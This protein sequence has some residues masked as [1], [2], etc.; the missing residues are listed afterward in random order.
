M[1]RLRRT[2]ISRPPPKPC[3]AAGCD[4][5]RKARK[6][7]GP[8]YAADL[9]A[10]QPPAVR[11]AARRPARPARHRHRIPARVRRVV[12]ARAAGRCEGC[13]GWLPARPH[14]HHRRLLSQGGR[15]EPA[16]LVA[17]CPACHVD[18]PLT[19]RERIAESGRGHVLP[20]HKHVA[21]ARDL[22]LIV[23]GTADPAAESLVLP[24][25]RVVWLHPVEARYLDV[26]LPAAA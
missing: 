25:G 19:G 1:S 13:G 26:G 5:P 7:C 23:E 12:L 4:R 18:L 17:L 6:L 24:A 3:T 15:D 16:N 11:L 10:K 22:G 20:V 9:R 14:L 8:H 2:G 21:A